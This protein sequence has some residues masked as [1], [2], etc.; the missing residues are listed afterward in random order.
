LDSIFVVRSKRKSF[1][2]MAPSPTESHGWWADIEE[3]RSAAQMK[4]LGRL[5]TE[6]Q[7]CPLYTFKSEASDC[8]QCGR[9]FGVLARRHHCRQ[10]GVIVCEACSR[11]KVRIPRLDERMLFKACNK[12]T[13][14]LKAERRYG[15][16]SVI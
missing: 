5:L 7:C 12:C 4:Q 15:A 6:E 1:Y 13:A 10:C 8:S 11:N 2:V 9:S 16:A 14:L 3:A